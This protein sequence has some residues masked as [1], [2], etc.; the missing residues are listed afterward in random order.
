MIKPIVFELSL[1]QLKISGSELTVSMLSKC[2]AS[3]QDK[4]NPVF[5]LSTYPSEHLG[6]ILPLETAPILQR[7]FRKF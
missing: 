1:Y 5:G 2:P 4:G 3:G 6:P 7:M